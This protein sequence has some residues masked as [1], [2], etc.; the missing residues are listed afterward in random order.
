MADN[1]STVADANA[2]LP[3]STAI[4]T[5]DVGGVHY[6][7]IKLDVG[8][9]GA[10][11]PVGAAGLPV[12]DAGGSLTVDGTVG[13]SGSVAVTGTF[14][15]ATQPVSVASAV[16]VTDNGGSL[17]VDGTFW[18]ATQPV[19]GTVTANAGTNLNTSL[20]AT[21]AELE[22][23]TAAT[24]A[25]G[26]AVAAV[27]TAI[28]DLGADADA[29]DIVYLAKLDDIIAATEA[30]QA[31]VQTIDNAISGSEMQVD[32]V[33][34]ALPSGASTAA[35]QPALGT[36]GTA[37]ADVLT[38]Q[39][40]ASMT[41]LK[42]DGSAVT[43]PV[44]AASLPLPSGASTSAKQDTA[45]T[46]LDAIKTAVEVLDNT[47]SGSELQVDVVAALPSGDNNIGN[48]DVVTLPS[49]P[50]G[51]NNIGDV[52]VLTLPALV[53]GT[54]TIGVVMDE[55]VSTSTRSS[56]PDSATNVTV[57]ASNANRKAAFFFNDSDQIAYLALGATATTS[58]YTVKMAAGGF[59][60]IP[61]P[62]YTGIVDCIWASNST[63]SMR[64][65]ELT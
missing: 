34:S 23:T 40:I 33:S 36:A 12:N 48:V 49:I 2:T 63:G 29:A 20:L 5:D 17:T 25:V 60:E 59:Y 4:A 65:T 56:T 62:V 52:D 11:S 21:E 45:Q 53:A 18:Q 14:F 44:S 8:A 27:E 46:A 58:D 1:V 47:V 6:Q 38:V 30:T 16:P 3:A 43:Q 57:L 54:A 42:T 26:T 37:S 35:K 7:R 10:A 28:E 64:V 50:A 32:I 24:L 9:D 15:Q 55:R 22:A 39:G 61:A 31:A 13:V 19:S 51:T 41:A